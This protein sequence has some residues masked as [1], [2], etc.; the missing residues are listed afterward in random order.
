HAPDILEGKGVPATPRTYRHIPRRW[1][2]ILSLRNPAKG[3]AGPPCGMHRRVER[4]PQVSVLRSNK[5]AR[6]VPGFAATS[7]LPSPHPPVS[8]AQCTTPNFTDTPRTAMPDR[9]CDDLVSA[10]GV[11]NRRDRMARPLVAAR[12]G[13]LIRASG[14]PR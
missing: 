7:T 14:P 8:A 10:R 12:P 13:R 9:L 1:R 4:T 6:H 3:L 2:S 11:G 5:R